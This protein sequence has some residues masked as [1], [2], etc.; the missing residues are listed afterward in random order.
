MAEKVVIQN[1]RISNF[2]RHVTFTLTLDRATWHTVV[3]HLL[4]STYTANLIRIGKTFCG[5]TYVL[6]TDGQTDIEAGFIRL[7]RGRVR[8]G[9]S[10]Q[11]GTLSTRIANLLC[12]IHSALS[13]LSCRANARRPCYARHTLSGLTALCRTPRR[14]I[15]SADRQATDT[16]Y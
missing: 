5:R 12:I 14:S 10:F 6:H 3:H 8:A 9:P 16:T 4:T 7:T 1:G 11:L 13:R 15:Y 2:Q